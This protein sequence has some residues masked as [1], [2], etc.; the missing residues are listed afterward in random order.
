MVQRYSLLFVVLPLVVVFSS[1]ATHSRSAAGSSAVRSTGIVLTPGGE[2]L[3]VVNPDSGSISIVDIATL[4]VDERAVGAMPQSIAVDPNG[5]RAYVTLKD[6]DAILAFPLVGLGPEILVETGP[7]PFGVLVGTNGNLYV[8]VSGGDRID[9]FET[10]TL[11]RVGAIPTEPQ[12]RGL[13]LSS[14][15]MTLYVT[16]LLSGRVSVI[17]AKTRQVVRVISTGADSNLSESVVLDEQRQ[18]AWVPQTRSN[19]SNTALLFDT[20]LFPIVSAIDLATFANDNR[21]RIAIDIADRPVNMPSAAVLSTKGI[22]WVVNAGSNDVSAID[23]GKGSAIAHIEV[24]DNPR[25]LV[26][27]PDE[28][29]LFVSNALAGTVSVIDTT[30]LRVIN[31]IR[32]TTLP[33]PPDILRGKILFHSSN[34]PSLA[35]DQWISCAACHPDGRADG[36][37]WFFRDGPRNTPTLV[38][39]GETGPW[40]WSGDLDELADAENTIRVV[41]AGTGLAGGETNCIPACDQAPPNG[42]RSTD[43]DALAVFMR[44]LRTMGRSPELAE[45]RKLTTAGARGRAIFNSAEAGCAVC[46]VSS[47]FT[48]RKKHDVGTGRSS[49]FERK[50]TSFDTPSLRFLFST[51]PYLHDGSAA[52]L[53]DV[54]ST[55]NRDDLHGRTSHLSSGDLDDLVVFLRSIPYQETRRRGVRK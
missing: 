14:D 35:K 37:T 47:V 1:G 48:D 53:R 36:R 49:P 25:A 11:R 10:A 52:T 19:T 51:A 45:D 50:G 43:L 27:S 6:Q 13:A 20:T 2:R 31:E 33:L 40:H 28:S 38:D 54:L 8:S 39:V 4:A 22:L 26:L 44:T 24:G 29:R 42:G 23:L 41:Q 55:G 3:L 17:D 30:S 46:H 16:H 34:L 21:R 15:E 9:V 7:E 32:V 18:I 12:P 5:V